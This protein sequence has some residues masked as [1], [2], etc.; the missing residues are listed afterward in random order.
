MTERTRTEMGQKL[1][2]LNTETTAPVSPSPVRTTNVS[3]LKVA[4]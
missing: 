3:E 2:P 4:E 1:K